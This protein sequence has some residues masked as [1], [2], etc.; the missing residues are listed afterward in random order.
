M[1]V[2]NSIATIIM[3]L[4]WFYLAPLLG[5]EEYGKISFLVATGSLIYIISM[6]GAGP[7]ITVFT[8]KE[9]KSQST[10]FFIPLIISLI[11]SIVIFLIF[12]NIGISLFIIGS[13]IFALT[14]ADL[15]GK[16]QY[17]KF[18]IFVIIQ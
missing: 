9:K 6:V 5:S 8:S 3:G 1:G 11:L 13:V 12:Y 16:K 4:F 2:A 14:A 15:L 7:T 18:S 17:Q 10:I